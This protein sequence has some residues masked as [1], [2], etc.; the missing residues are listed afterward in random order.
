MMFALENK[1][2]VKKPFF[3]FKNSMNFK[4]F[5]S[6]DVVAIFLCSTFVDTNWIEHYIN[7]ASC[8]CTK[9]NLKVEPA[10]SKAKVVTK[11]LHTQ[12]KLTLIPLFILYLCVCVCVRKIGVEKKPNFY[13]KICS[14]IFLRTHIDRI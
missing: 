10:S 13:P 6:I 5:A 1:I 9:K 7:D 8:K 11:M 14:T 4:Y 3:C 12:V 2:L